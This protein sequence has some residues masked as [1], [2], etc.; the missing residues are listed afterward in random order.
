MSEAVHT[1]PVA[2]KPQNPQKHPLQG[3]Q[4]SF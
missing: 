1:T 3:V 2:D 4:A